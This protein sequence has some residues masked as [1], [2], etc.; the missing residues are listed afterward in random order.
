MGAPRSHQRTRDEKEGRSPIKALSFRPARNVCRFSIPAP[1]ALWVFLSPH[2]WLCRFL[3]PRT[4]RPVGFSNPGTNRPVCSSVPHQSLCRLSIPAPIALSVR[5]SRTNRSVGF[6]IPARIALSVSLSP[7]QSPGAPHLAR[8]L[9]D[10][11][12]HSSSPKLSTN[13]P[14][15]KHLQLIQRAWPIRFQQPR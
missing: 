14:T 7:H 12:F 2:Q 15:L 1:I 5:L 3:Y 6:S 10:V 4:N 8:F 11:G 9:R 13:S